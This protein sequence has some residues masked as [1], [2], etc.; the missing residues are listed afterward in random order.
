MERG[1]PRGYDEDLVVAL[2][3]VMV[4]YDIK[5]IQGLHK[6]LV[7]NEDIAKE[8]KIYPVPSRRTIGRRMKEVVPRFQ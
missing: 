2:F 1:R 3:A 4:R 8:N 7:E 5:S 6:F